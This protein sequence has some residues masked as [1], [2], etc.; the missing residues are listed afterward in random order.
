MKK[1]IITGISGQVGS[2]MSEYCLNL[3]YKVWGVVRRTSRLNTENFKHL[4]ENENLCILYADLTDGGSIEEVVKTVLPDY[5]INLAAQSFVGVSWKIPEETFNVDAMGVIRCLES[6]RKTVPNCRFYNAGSSEQF[7]N[8]DYSPQDETHP[9]KPRSPYGAAKCAAHHIIKVYRESYGLY[10]CSGILFNHE[11][12][13]RGHNF[14]TRK[15][16]I[17]LGNIVKG[18]QDKLV[19]G[20][21]NSLRDWG[22]ARDYVEGMYLMLQQENPDDYVLS[23]N[24]Y[25]SVR[26][27]IEI[28]FGIK[29][30]NI[31]WKNTG[32]NEIGYD[33]STG[34]ELIFISDKYFRLAEVDELLGD[35]TKA[36]TCLGWAPK[37]DF[38]DLV[39]EMVDADCV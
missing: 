9:F 26:E 4:I 15:I 8:V 6:I 39:K 31:K 21:L 24:E 17:A 14:V 5:F 16:T 10:A 7:G 20:N 33:E 36:R 3:G 1:V 34:K 23:T 30:Y 2:Y 29:G 22:H 18:K 25:H 37:C 35:S 38:K 12:P 19:L 28:A 32:L 13:R 27:F 11:S